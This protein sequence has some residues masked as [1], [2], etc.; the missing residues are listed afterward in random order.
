MVQNHASDP[1]MTCVYDTWHSTPSSPV[2]FRKIALIKVREAAE[3]SLNLERNFWLGTEGS[4]PVVRG[5]SVSCYGTLSYVNWRYSYDEPLSQPDANRVYRCIGIFQNP[6]ETGCCQSSICN[7]YDQDRV[8]A[9]TLGT[10]IGV[11]R[12]KRRCWCSAGR[13]TSNLYLQKPGNC[14]RCIHGTPRRWTSTL[15]VSSSRWQP[16]SPS[17]RS[18][19]AIPAA[20]S[21]SS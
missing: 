14:I 4:F 17:W 7:Y 10:R 6:P 19:T 11:E 3:E 1:H 8:P 13:Y 16:L 2:K 20:K 9:V 21:K 12:G 5:D 18:W 15:L